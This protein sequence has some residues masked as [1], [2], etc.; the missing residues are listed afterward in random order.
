[1]EIK[2]RTETIEISEQEYL[3]LKKTINKTPSITLNKEVKYQMQ[4]TV[5]QVQDTPQR[6]HMGK[7]RNKHDVLIKN[8][9]ADDILVSTRASNQTA[10][11]LLQFYSDLDP[12]TPLTSTR[13]ATFLS[14]K[15]DIDKG[16]ASCKVGLLVK[17]GLYLVQPQKMHYSTLEPLI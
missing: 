17:E 7:L 9:L 10:F 15:L 14:Q 5:A 13:A 6:R 1:M 11:N 12:E 3:A 2:K 16:H 4:V 8:P